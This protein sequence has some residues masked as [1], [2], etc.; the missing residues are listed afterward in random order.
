MKTNTLYA[1]DANCE[2]EA[3]ITNTWSSYITDEVRW[4][5]E[6]VSMTEDAKLAFIEAMQNGDVS[7]SQVTW[8]QTSSRVGKYV[9]VYFSEDKTS[10]LE[11]SG[12]VSTRGYQYGLLIGCNGG[13][14]T[15]HP[16]PYLFLTP[17]YN[18]PGTLSQNSG[19]SSP[20]VTNFFTTVTQNLPTGYAGVSIMTQPTGT[21]YVA[22]GDSFSSGEGSFNYDLPGGD[23]HRSTDSYAYYLKNNLPLETLDFVACS[24]A[25]SDDFF[26]QNSANPMED[27]QLDHLNHDTQVVTLTIGGNDMG[28]ANVM[29]ECAKYGDH[30]GYGCSSDSTLTNTMNDR[31]AALDGTA[32][33]AMYIDGR[34][35][36][37]LSSIIEEIADN[38]PNASIYIAGYPKLFG[39]STSY[40]D[41]DSSAPGGYKCASFPASFSYADAQWM[42]DWADDINSAI[43]GAV[44]DAV[45]SSID[46]H[47]VSP[48]LFDSH[49]LC[50]SGGSWINWV[51]LDSF[52]HSKS[53]SFHPTPTG[54]SLGY[55]LIF[56]T[57]IS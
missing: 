42:N 51:F 37:S 20:V 13:L 53:E 26:H 5:T 40:F 36:H 24:G 55:G 12:A 25:V 3:N 32:S 11:W 14:D 38:A 29:N 31:L 43:S 35:I 9:T 56:E 50:D 49:G 10:N 8:Q 41:A 44:D 1:G 4:G 30:P 18:S 16:T 19:G 15:A 47:Y 7:V 28:F 17:T 33:T 6:V 23:C 22:M 34:E 39:S 27:A 57:T 46:A 45:L 2:F 52:D 48:A 21:K 54:M